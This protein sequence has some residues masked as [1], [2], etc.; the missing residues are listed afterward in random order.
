MRRA[1]LLF[2]SCLL[3]ACASQQQAVKSPGKAARVVA[4]QTGIAS[5]YKDH[6]TASGER[7]SASAFAAAHRTWPLRCT[8]RCT[9]LDNGRWV[10]VRIND[11][12][13][14]IRGRV[15]DLTPAAAH[16]IGLSS[17]QGVCRVKIERI[18]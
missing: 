2:T 11:R 16:A 6:R 3:A 5:I 15:I 7:Y 8:C 12:G 4:T 10:V 14:Y 13:P 18:E 17:R 9:N 1:F